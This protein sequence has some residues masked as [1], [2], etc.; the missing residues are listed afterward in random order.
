MYFDLFIPL[1][2]YQIINYEKKSNDYIIF[3]HE[4]YL[5]QFIKGL[6]RNLLVVKGRPLFRL[7]KHILFLSFIHF[8]QPITD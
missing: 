3:Y 4:S 8:I 2:N 5:L 7:F 1:S 6:F